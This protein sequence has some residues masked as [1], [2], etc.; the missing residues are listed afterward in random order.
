MCSSDLTSGRQDF[1]PF[2][3]FSATSAAFLRSTAKDN[4]GVG[5]VRVNLN[6]QGWQTASVT[7]TMKPDLTL[8]ANFLQPPVI[9]V[10]PTSQ[11]DIENQG[12]FRGTYRW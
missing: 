6:N 10:Q 2:L 1:P 8:T 11:I 3:Q 4:A 12:D 5:E 7:F 9:A